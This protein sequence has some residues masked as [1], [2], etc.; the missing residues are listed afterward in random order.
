GA[1]AQWWLYVYTNFGTYY[2]NLASYSFVPGYTVTHQG[3]LF[4]L[5]ST[6]VFIAQGWLPAGNYLFVFE[7]KTTDGESYRDSVA[8]NVFN[9]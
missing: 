2:F 9:K 8:V 4:D 3:K 6:R 1:D 7:V 5:P